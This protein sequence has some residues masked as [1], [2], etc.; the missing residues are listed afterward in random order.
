MDPD[1][2]YLYHIDPTLTEQQAAKAVVSRIISN[3]HKKEKKLE[4]TGA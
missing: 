1:N 3:E 2:K 4:V